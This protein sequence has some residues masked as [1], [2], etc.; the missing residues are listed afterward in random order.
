[1]VPDYHNIENLNDGTEAPM[2][3]RERLR[4]LNALYLSIENLNLMIQFLKLCNTLRN[5]CHE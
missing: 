4:V 2:M 5:I 1:M 3:L